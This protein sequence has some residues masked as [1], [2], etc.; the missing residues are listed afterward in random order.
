MAETSSTPPAARYGTVRGL[1]T[2]FSMTAV[3]LIWEG[4]TYQMAA[5]ANTMKKSI[6]SIS[7][8]AFFCFKFCTSSFRGVPKTAL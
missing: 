3:T 8:K 5:A 4:I 2:S 6:R 7:V 1:M